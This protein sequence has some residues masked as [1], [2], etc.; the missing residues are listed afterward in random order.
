MLFDAGCSGGTCLL[1]LIC[2]SDCTGLGIDIDDNRIALANLHSKSIMENGGM[3]DKDI[4]VA[5]AF[6]DITV[7]KNL[8]AITV[9][10]LYD[11]AFS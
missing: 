4:K 7:F 2:L 10:Y 5:F 6:H 3:H 8:N 9:L 11:S 1:V